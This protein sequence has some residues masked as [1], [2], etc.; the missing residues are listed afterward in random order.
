VIDSPSGGMLE[1]A[2]KWDLM[3]TEGCSGGKVFLWMP[4]VVLEYM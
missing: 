4:L 1:K 3:G 2:P